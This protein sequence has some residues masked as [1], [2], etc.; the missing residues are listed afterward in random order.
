MSDHF[1]VAHVG[2]F[3]TW[4]TIIDARAEA[5]YLAVDAPNQH[6]IAIYKL[7]EVERRFGRGNP[8]PAPTSPPSGVAE[9]DAQ[10]LKKAA[11]P[12]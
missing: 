1:V 2:S 6:Q 12:R 11:G 3:V 7:V 10:R 5:A 4:P 9:F 8:P